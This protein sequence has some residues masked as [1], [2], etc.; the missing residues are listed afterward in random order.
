MANCWCSYLVLL[1][2]VLLSPHAWRNIICLS[3]SCH[4]SHASHSNRE[5]CSAR[6]AQFL[7]LLVNVATL[8]DL[9]QWNRS[10]TA[11]DDY[12]TSSNHSRLQRLVAGTNLFELLCSST[13]SG[14]QL[15]PAATISTAATAAPAA[16]ASD[17]ALAVITALSSSAQKL[18][19]HVIELDE[20][21]STANSSCTEGMLASIDTIGGLAAAA[22]HSK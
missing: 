19:D 4:W 3:S 22:R 14:L 6:G 13:S 1:L 17:S 11:L 16:A 8:A 15:L 18:L 7:P 5:R 12:I 20:S 9:G 21:G 2:L 10:A